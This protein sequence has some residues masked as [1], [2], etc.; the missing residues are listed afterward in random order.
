VAEILPLSAAVEA[1]VHDGDTVAFESFTHLMRTL[2][3][4]PAERS[5]TR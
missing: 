1:L 5:A 4:R 2:M 3:A